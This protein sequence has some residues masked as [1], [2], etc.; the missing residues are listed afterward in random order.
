MPLLCGCYR[1]AMRLLCFFDQLVSVGITMGSDGF[2]W[3]HI[4]SDGLH[5]VALC[6]T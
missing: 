1:V 6:C 5:L 3:V 4:G 2:I